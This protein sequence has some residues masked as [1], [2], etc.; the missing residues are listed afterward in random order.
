MRFSSTYLFPLTAAFLLLVRCTVGPEDPPVPVPPDCRIGS[1]SIQAGPDMINASIDNSARTVTVITTAWM[2]DLDKLVPIFT[3]GGKVTVEGVE[4]V[5][6]SSAVDFRGTGGSVVYTVTSVT[7]RQATYTVTI[8]SPM[9]SGL[10]SVGIE[11]DG[12]VEI[13]KKTEIYHGARI[14]IEHPDDPSQNLA[15]Q[16]GIRGRGNTSWTKPKKPWRIR[17]DDPVSVLGIA[18]ARSWVLLANWQDPTL[19]MNEVAFELGRRFEIPYTNN[20]RFVE[21][22]INGTYRG[23]YQLTEQIQAGKNRVAIDEDNGGFLAELDTYYDEVPKFR[24]ASFNLPV[25]VKDPDGAAA[26]DV[27]PV[28]DALEAV[29]MGGGVW[30]EHADEDSFIDYMLV[31]EIVRNPEAGQPKSLF[32]YRHDGSSKLCFGPLWDFDWAFA[33]AA[34]G[35]F[36]YFRP[37]NLPVLYGPHR[38]ETTKGIGF[39][40]AF[41]KDP[42]LRARYKARWNEMMDRG[43]IEGIIPFIGELSK[44]LMKSQ[45]HNFARWPNGKDPAEQIS[46]M[47][48]WLSARIEMLDREI[49][50]F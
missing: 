1:F 43:Q 49:N 11:V 3:A 13:T 8:D 15:S 35:S 10:P 34:D 28:F 23:N 4:Q 33:Y 45:R 39:I 40:N 18:P 2:D 32:M 25:M 24:T 22:W 48:S 12:G 17:F 47:Q 42:G 20:S 38:T 36:D 41:Y 6:G 7:G 5:S 44:S 30:Q 16:V 14:T 31:T 50:K 26:A 29:L 19:I 9:F 21:L 46:L 27:K 37:K